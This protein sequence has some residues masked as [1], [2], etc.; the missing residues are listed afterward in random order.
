MIRMLKQFLVVISLGSL[1]GCGMLAPLPH[2]PYTRYNL[3]LPQKS[4]VHTVR[5]AKTKKVILVNQVIA[6][7]G[8]DSVKMVYEK[9]PFHYDHYVYHAWLAPPADMLMPIVAAGLR[10]KHYYS[11]VVSAPFEGVS[12]YVLSLRLIE[13][14]QDFMQPTS[15]E[16]LSVDAVLL[17][18]KSHRVLAERI[19]NQ[20]M[21]ALGN[22]PYSGVLA[23]AQCADQISSS[24][25]RFA[26]SA[27]S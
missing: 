17:D 4:L 1:A 13:L 3:S 12:D 21:P 23:A 8:F 20:A 18:A 10:K 19:F 11:A 5:A 16:R 2:K 25:A 14:V 22:D 7:S 15:V 24:I 9:V 27:S 6:S 26:V